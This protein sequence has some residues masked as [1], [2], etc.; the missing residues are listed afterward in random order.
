MQ[1]IKVCVMVLTAC[2]VSAAI[3][4]VQAADPSPKRDQLDG[5]PLVWKPTTRPSELKPVKVSD[6]SNVRLEV[7]TFTDAR[8]EPKLIG[9]NREEPEPR[10]VVTVNDVAAF[11]SDRLRQMAIN[12]GIAV[13]DTGGTHVLSGEVKQFFVDETKRY[14]GEVLLDVTLKDAS[15]RTLWAG[16]AS[17]STTRFGRSYKA[18]NYYEV[19]SD[20]LLQAG[21]ALLGNSTFHDALA[22]P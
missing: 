1:S 6:L 15:G 7:A 2:V 13:V 22:K 19:L 11:V 20:A 4:V 8:A 12:T 3:N 9:Q 5:I 17:G 10:K 21:Y 18:D 14:N 16:T